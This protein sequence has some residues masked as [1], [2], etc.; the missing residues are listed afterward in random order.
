MVVPLARSDP[1]GVEDG[2]GAP[3][4]RVPA[5]GVYAYGGGVGGTDGPKAGVEASCVAGLAV[6]LALP[7]HHVLLIQRL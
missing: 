6:D 7:K 3:G 5:T 4:T 2:P 1:L